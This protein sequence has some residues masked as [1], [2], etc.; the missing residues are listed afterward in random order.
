M[1]VARP[2]RLDL[3]TLFLNIGLLLKLRTGK[4]NHLAD[5]GVPMLFAFRIR[6]QN[7]EN[8]PQPVVVFSRGIPCRRSVLIAPNEDIVGWILILKLEISALSKAHYSESHLVEDGYI[9][10][11][12]PEP[13]DAMKH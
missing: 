9:N 12:H 2:L 11:E 7:Y 5:R 10:C 8:F 13:A 4:L 1:I 3:D 6:L